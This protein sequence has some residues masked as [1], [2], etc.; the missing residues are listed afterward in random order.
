MTRP[1]LGA[2]LYAEEKRVKPEVPWRPNTSEDKE[3]EAIKESI[4]KVNEEEAAKTKVQ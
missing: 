3:L 2:N 1:L 4:A